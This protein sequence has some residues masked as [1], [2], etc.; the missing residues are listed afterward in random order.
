ME[1]IVLEI[2]QINLVV[3]RFRFPIEEYK[4][5]A[6]NECDLTC[7]L[8]FITSKKNGNGREGQ[9]SSECEGF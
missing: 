9:L 3:L 4:I 2:F 5:V 6:G 7:R 1:A 8:C